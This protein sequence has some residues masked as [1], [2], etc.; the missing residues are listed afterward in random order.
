MHADRLQ[1][2]RFEIKYLVPD[3]VALSAR[4]F[5]RAYLDADEFSATRADFSYPVHSLYLDS[6]EM[7]FYRQTLNGDKNRLKMRARFYDQDIDSPV[8]LEIKRR[9]NDTISKQR[10]AIRREALWTVLRG[11]LPEPSMIV[12]KGKN[13]AFAL[14]NFLR[15][16]LAHQAK[17]VAHVRYLREAWVSRADNS[18]RVTMDRNVRFD[19]QAEA[20]LETSM[21]D[22]IAVFDPE[23]VLELKFTNRCPD[24]FEQLARVFN[25]RQYS[26]A[27]YA[28]GVTL[29]GRHR[30]MNRL[31]QLRR[32]AYP[33]GGLAQAFTEERS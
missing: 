33:D 3:S 20:R 14:D 15:L 22:P 30:M 4:D 10:C 5:V 26:A 23:V 8:F 9:T 28:E 2:Q 25:L 17:P 11:Q 32:H 7:V 21:E 13:A 27:K 12:S 18:L 16:L 19:V 31:H 29:F 24:W 1:A 6:D